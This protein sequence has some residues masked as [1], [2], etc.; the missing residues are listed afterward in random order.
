MPENTYIFISFLIPNGLPI[1]K[2]FVAISIIM[3]CHI[4]KSIFVTN[5]NFHKLIEIGR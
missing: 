5:R 1:M 3:M 2:E 4:K